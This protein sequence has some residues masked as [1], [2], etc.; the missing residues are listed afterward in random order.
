[1]NRGTEI[2][3]CV[4]KSLKIS[5]KSKDTLT[6]LKAIK[7]LP[8]CRNCAVNVVLKNDE[9]LPLKKE[10]WLFLSEV[11]P[12]LQDV[13]SGDYQSSGYGCYGHSVTCHR[14]LSTEIEVLQSIFILC[15]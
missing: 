9:W 15:K 1:M 6:F 4:N 10:I 5:P 12:F 3:K 11:F 8:N 7:K 14:F 13:G 2:V